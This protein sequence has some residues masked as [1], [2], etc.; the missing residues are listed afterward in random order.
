MILQ[1]F[2]VSGAVTVYLNEVFNNFSIYQID[3][4][5]FYR[6]LKGIISKKR[7]GRER[8][9]FFKHHKENKD[10][11]LIHSFVPHLKRREV[12]QFLDM[13]KNDEDF[14]ERFLITVGLKEEKKSKLT[15]V[16][17]KEVVQRTKNM[18]EEEK[19]DHKPVSISAWEDSFA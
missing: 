13:I 1:S 10:I 19:K 4:M 5:E 8:S 2:S 16:E 18:K 3:K 17:K 15:A 11:T 6:Y 7:I 12:S 9:C 14:E